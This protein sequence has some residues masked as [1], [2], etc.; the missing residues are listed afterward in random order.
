MASPTAP[1][2]TALGNDASEK[3]SI[4]ADIP[5]LESQAASNTEETS[6]QT[7]DGRFYDKL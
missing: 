5:K 7:E 3:C 4:S 6:K 1:T 2:E